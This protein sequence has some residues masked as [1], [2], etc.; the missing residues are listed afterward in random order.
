MLYKT[1]I[2]PIHTYGSESEPLTRKD[3]ICSESLREE[4]VKKILVCGL[5]AN[6]FERNYRLIFR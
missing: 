3:K 1:L 5:L 6:H 4:K 2:R